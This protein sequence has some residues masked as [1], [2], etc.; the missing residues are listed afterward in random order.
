M[1]WTIVLIWLVYMLIGMA[2]GKWYWQPLPRRSN[3]IT[4]SA[5]GYVGQ[6]L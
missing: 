2:V 1:F 4:T 6:T 5:S 3:R